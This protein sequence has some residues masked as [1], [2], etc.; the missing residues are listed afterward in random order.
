M[1]NYYDDDSDDTYLDSKQDENWDKV[2]NRDSF[3]LRRE[4]ESEGKHA[5]EF[6]RLTSGDPDRY[7]EE[8]AVQHARGAATLAL[9]Y[10]ERN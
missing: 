4:A 10:L 6:I 2:G 7:L 9:E 8:K 1:H 5:V 3:Q